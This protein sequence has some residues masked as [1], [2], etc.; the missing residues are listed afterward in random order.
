M[1]WMS[2]SGI[3]SCLTL[4]GAAG[5]AADAPSESIGTQTQALNPSPEEPDDP[6]QPPT[7][8][9]TTTT[10]VS[11][12]VEGISAQFRLEDTSIFEDSTSVQQVYGSISLVN[13]TNGSGTV[14][15]LGTWANPDD[16]SAVSWGT[17]TGQ[18]P[19]RF[20]TG[21][22]DAYGHPLWRSEPTYFFKDTK[23]CTSGSYSYCSG[24]FLYNNQQMTV[25][26]KE[27]DSVKLSFDFRDY[28]SVYD[29]YFCGGGGYGTV[30]RLGTYLY[31][32]IG[33]DTSSYLR[34]IDGS[35]YPSN[36]QHADAK[37][38]R[39]WIDN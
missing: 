38:C 7:T 6:S 11:L 1:N 24:Y 3:V 4:F 31:I 20:V 14:R 25:A 5:C 8:P 30:K 22:N 27:G 28:D 2:V 33:S 10:Y 21:G 36:P 18:A 23:L 32:E 19:K 34:A 26:A 29:D 15:N 12:R 37:G 13:L 16:L 9:T 39:I 17:T 35:N